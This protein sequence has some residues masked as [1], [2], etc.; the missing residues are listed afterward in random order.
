M[1]VGALYCD[2]GLRTSGF[3]GEGVK[4]SAVI[5]V[6]VHGKGGYMSNQKLPRR[7]GNRTVF[8]AAILLI[9]NPRD[10]LVAEWHRE[11]SNKNHNTSLNNHYLSVNS[12]YFGKNI[13]CFRLS[14]VM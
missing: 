6:K 7:I 2:C 3:T 4:G 11:R 9:R 1:Y 13:E 8:G 12:T 10:A 14:C 5:A